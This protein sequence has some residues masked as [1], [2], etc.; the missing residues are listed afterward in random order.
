VPL[1]TTIAVLT[2][3][4]VA[5]TVSELMAKP[6]HSADFAAATLDVT[7]VASFLV[8]S[9]ELARSAAPGA[10]LQLSQEL[11][12]ACSI[13]VDERFLALMAS[14][15]GITSSASTGITASAILLDL[16]AALSRL[17]IGADS[18]LWFIVPP[19]VAKVM[20]LLQGTGGFIVQNNKIGAVSV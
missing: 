6:V 7:K 16:T 2:S 5:E 14:T 1:R 18:R 12:R 10:M 20:S 17:T 4:P 9:N 8:V 15:P 13:A 19:K 11:R 3:A